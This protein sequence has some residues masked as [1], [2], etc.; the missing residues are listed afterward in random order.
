MTPMPQPSERIEKPSDALVSSVMAP[1]KAL[2][3]PM[4]P[5]SVPEMIRP[6]NAWYDRRYEGRRVPKGGH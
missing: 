1:R 6:S 4:F 3:A 2:T 5:F